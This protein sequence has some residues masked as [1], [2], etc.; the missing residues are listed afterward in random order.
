MIAVI[1]RVSE[2]SVSINQHQIGF[3]KKGYVILV[4]IFDT[5]TDIDLNK[6]VHKIVNL[7]IMA[8]NSN[9]MNLSILDVQGEI[10]AIP[11]FTLCANLNQRRPSFI[12]AKNPKDAK[13]LYKLFIH[14]LQTFGIKV[15]SGEFGAYMQV[16][17]QNDGPVTIIINSKSN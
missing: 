10:L 1:Q 15:E 17:I 9:K 4:G 5:D 8:D 12:K 14:K 3:I 13:Q 7:R 16:S 2:G 11:Q 6:L